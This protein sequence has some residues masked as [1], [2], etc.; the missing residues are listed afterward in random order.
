MKTIKYLLF[1]ITLLFGVSA[2]AVTVSLTGNWVGA[3]GVYIDSNGDEQPYW[4]GIVELEIDGKRHLAMP[5]YP[6]SVGSTPADYLG[7]SWDSNLY[8]RDDILA[9]GTNTLGESLDGI[10]VNGVTIDATEIYPRASQIFFYGLL[11]YNPPDPLW[12]ASFSEMISQTTVF[13]PLQGYEDERYFYNANITYDTETG[14][15]LRDVYDLTIIPELIPNYDYSDF[16]RVLEYVDGAPSEFLVFTSTVP[17]PSA[18][19][20]FGSG[21]I[22]FVAIARKRKKNLS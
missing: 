19:W 13:V 16:M 1:T 20:L 17:V 11:G 5:S 10:I 18:V 8:T 14:L 4:A 12:A 22:G 9:G 2:G 7:V 15:T 3:E 21:L 6:W